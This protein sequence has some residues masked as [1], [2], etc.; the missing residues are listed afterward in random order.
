MTTPDQA[1]DLMLAV[2]KA[3]WDQTGYTARYPDNPGGPPQNA[4]PWARVTVRHALGGQTSLGNSSGSIKYT[5]AGSLIIQIFVP[6]G[7]GM[8]SGYVLAR[9]VLKAYRDARGAVW[10]RNHR[11]RE[12]GSDGAYT[13]INCTIDFSYDDA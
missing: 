12:V 11:F 9:T 2:F 1:I 10:Y 3:A 7:D 6:M 5:H 4:E 8:G 13:Q